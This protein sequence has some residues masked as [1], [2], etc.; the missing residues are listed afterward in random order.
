MWR[1]ELPDDRLGPATHGIDLA[2]FAV[3]MCLTE[4]PASPLFVLLTFAL[5]SAKLR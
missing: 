4:G 2:A 1:R 5:L 3:L